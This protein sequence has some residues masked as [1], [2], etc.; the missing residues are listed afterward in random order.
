MRNIPAAATVED[1]QAAIE[2]HGLSVKKVVFQPEEKKGEG[3]TQVALVRFPPMPLPWH[4]TEEELSVPVLPELQHTP[5]AKPEE[6]KEGEEAKK[7]AEAGAEVKKEEG[8]KKEAA[9]GEGE[10]KKEG[11]EAKKEGEEAKK[12]GEEAAA[13]PAEE[14]KKK[15]VLPATP[16]AKPAVVQPAKPL[17]DGRKDGDVFVFA[18]FVAT[19]LMQRRLAVGDKVRPGSGWD[20]MGCP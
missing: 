9:A 7:E 2:E 10:A 8:A 17:P 11:E 5:A 20:G 3:Q 14:E 18:H 6:G 15:E 1:V 16:S 12:E 13:K 19:R 4:V